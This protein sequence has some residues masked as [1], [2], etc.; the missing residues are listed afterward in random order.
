M[1]HYYPVKAKRLAPK[2]R[3]NEVEET[4]PSERPSNALLKSEIPPSEE[5]TAVDESD[6]FDIS[7]EQNLEKQEANFHML[8][9][10]DLDPKYGPFV[11]ITRMQRWTRAKLAG[12][13]PP[14]EVHHL[15]L[16]Q[17]QIYDRIGEVLPGGW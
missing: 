2:R 12:L 13:D 11:G 4:V 10:F 14:K 1:E 16:H 8:R 3:K 15:L 9:M 17:P 7:E 5:H 6:T